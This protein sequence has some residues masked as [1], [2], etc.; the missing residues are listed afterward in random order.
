MRASANR[1][2][3]W[4]LDDERPQENVEGSERSEI[5]R[6]LI[7]VVGRR[8]RRFLAATGQH[9]DAQRARASR[10]NCFHCLTLDSL[11]IRR[12]P[13]PRRTCASTVQRLDARPHP[14]RHRLGPGH[15]RF[16]VRLD[17]DIVTRLDGSG[18]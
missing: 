7:V 4:N 10:K 11:P 2:R 16:E 6:R 9:R 15:D 14:R 13:P 8:R 12:G 1:H 5:G 18:R 3:G 17:L